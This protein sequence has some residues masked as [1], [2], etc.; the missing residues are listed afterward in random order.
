MG[1]IFSICIENK[2]PIIKIDIINLLKDKMKKQIYLIK[3]KNRDS[4]RV[5]HLKRQQRSNNR[6]LLPPKYPPILDKFLDI[7][8]DRKLSYSFYDH[9]QPEVKK[10]EKLITYFKAL[11]V[12]SFFS[13]NKKKK[14][15]R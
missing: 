10:C 12:M 3:W 5:R 14:L 2:K 7:L 1:K 4:K 11:K 9:K 13:L 15:F 6:P 8:T